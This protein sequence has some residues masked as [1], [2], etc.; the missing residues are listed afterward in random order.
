MERRSYE[1]NKISLRKD[2]EKQKLEG[3]AAVFNR[4]SVMLWGFREKIEPGFFEN[5]LSDDI[6]MLWQHDSAW[7][8]GRTR[9]RTLMVWEDERGLGFENEPPNTQIGRDAMVSIERGDVDQMS[10]GFTVLPNGDEWYEE[11]DGT[12]VR[13]LKRGGG[14]LTEISP[15]TFPAYKD[16]SVDIVRNAP[17]WVQRALKPGA[18]DSRAAEKARARMDLLRQRAKL[19]ERRR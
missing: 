14:K 11:D 1:L 5:S 9:A 19:L 10:F 2:G 8:L 12:L 15:V 17:E 7:V 18:N 4:L 6:R 16:T 3:Y 13:T